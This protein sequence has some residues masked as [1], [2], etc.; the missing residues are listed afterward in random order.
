MRP[1]GHGVGTPDDPTQHHRPI[2]LRGG[3]ILG[4]NQ[5]A[6]PLMERLPPVLAAVPGHRQ[7][8]GSRQGPRRGVLLSSAH[9]VNVDR[10]GC[11][12]PGSLAARV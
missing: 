3:S 7:G 2:R 1:V 11:Q 6:T 4:R 5:L 12:L 9:P 8:P 10:R